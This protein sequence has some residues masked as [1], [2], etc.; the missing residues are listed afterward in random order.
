MIMALIRS[1]SW[2]TFLRKLTVI[3]HAISKFVV[4]LCHSDASRPTR[5]VSLAL[6]LVSI[7]ISYRFE[8]IADCCL[9][10]GHFACPI[11]GGGLGL[12]YTIRLRV[13]GKRIVDFLFVLIE[14]F[15]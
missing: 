2:L 11:G 7:L 5:G 12:T 13:V 15:C 3:Y 4:L 8:V 9:N 10:F 1:V 14:L 6:V